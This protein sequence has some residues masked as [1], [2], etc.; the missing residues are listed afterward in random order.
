LGNTVEGSCSGKCENLATTTGTADTTTSQKIAK[1]TGN[2]KVEPDVSSTTATGTPSIS[3]PSGYAWETPS[4]LGATIQSGTWTLDLTTTAS[5]ATGTATLWATVWS[6]QTISLGT[7]K[8]LFKNWDNTTN[9]LGT[10]SATKRT[11]TTGTIGPF[12]NVQY[13]VVEWWV[14]YTVAGSSSTATVKET[15]VSSASDVITP[16]FT[17]SSS[18]SDSFSFSDSL[19]GNV[20]LPRSFSDTYTFSDS[21]V[22]SVGFARSISDTYSFAE[23]VARILTLSRGVGDVFGVS[24]SVARLLLLTRGLSD[25][26][27]FADSALRSMIFGR[28]ASDTYT[29]S[30]SVQANVILSRPPF[31]SFAFSDSVSASVIKACCTIN[32][33]QGME[34]KYISGGVRHNTTALSF[35]IDFGTNITVYG[36]YTV[37]WSSITTNSWIY[38]VVPA[39]AGIQILAN[40]SLSNIGFINNNPDIYHPYVYFTSQGPCHCVGWI[41]SQWVPTIVWDR[42]TINTTWTYFNYNQLLTEN[43]PA[44][45]H[46]WDFYQPH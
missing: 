45:S 3:T 44:G 2:Y 38:Q 43:G 4:T 21:V 33:P 46:E 31:D 26:F 8:F 9:I 42:T 11:Y 29:T 18:S 32:N 37:H 25:G 27:S 12:S 41:P 35:S 22:R 39:T 24:E 16:A 10:T 6:C 7:C 23:A 14:H 36:I 19:V 28:S 30:D 15:T 1:T 40:V 20:I 17:I 5:S 13:L 34:I